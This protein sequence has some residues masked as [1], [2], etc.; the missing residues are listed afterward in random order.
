MSAKQKGLKGSKRRREPAVRVAGASA[1][2]MFSALAL[3]VAISAAHA[4]D[5]STTDAAATNVVVA[6]TADS[7]TTV[8]AAVA[9]TADAVSDSDANLEQVTITGSHIKSDGF[10]SPTP[11]TSISS[12]EI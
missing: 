7:T 6:S 5:A 2:A 11:L 3:P 8:D 1:F 10:T 12:D 4:A 9:T